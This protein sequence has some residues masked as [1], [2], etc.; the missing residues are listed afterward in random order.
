MVDGRYILIK[1]L[2]L[3]INKSLIA[4]TN[5]YQSK[6]NI[7]TLYLVRCQHLI[8][9]RHKWVLISWCGIVYVVLYCTSWLPP[10]LSERLRNP[11][12][13][14]FNLLSRKITWPGQ[15][16]R[17]HLHQKTDKVNCQNW[18]QAYTLEPGTKSIK[19]IDEGSTSQSKEGQSDK[20][21]PVS[22]KYG[23]AQVNPFLCQYRSTKMSSYSLSYLCFF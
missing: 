3:M 18:E 1:H 8:R 20:D 22:Y 10:G 13:S 16:G 14:T 4:C 7:N 21:S 5:C 9:Y 17:C 12:M 19:Y 11:K 23:T 2:M 6:Q 15:N